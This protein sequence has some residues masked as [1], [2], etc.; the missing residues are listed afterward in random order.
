MNERKSNEAIKTKIVY[1][2]TQTLTTVDL[3]DVTFYT[4]D[5]MMRFR[6]RLQ[7]VVNKFRIIGYDEKGE[8]DDNATFVCIQP[9]GGNSATF[10]A[11]KSKCV[12]RIPG[13]YNFA[14]YNSTPFEYVAEKFHEKFH[15]LRA[16]Q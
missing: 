8:I 10:L 4:P 7:M 3:S 5:D 13:I 14:Q 16:E 2:K 15:S 11:T 9:S 12:L 1:S 6:D